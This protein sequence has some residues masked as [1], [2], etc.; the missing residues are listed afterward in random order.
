MTEY[1][2]PYKVGLIYVG[3]KFARPLLAWSRIAYTANFRGKVVF[4]GR[5]VANYNANIAPHQSAQV[6]IQRAWHQVC[7]I[8]FFVRRLDIWFGPFGFF[9]SS[10][11]PAI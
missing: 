5:L 8:F 7:G 2:S 3:T 10:T 11:L 4:V 6:I 1:S 9:R